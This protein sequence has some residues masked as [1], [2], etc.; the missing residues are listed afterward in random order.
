[1]P[2]FLAAAYRDRSLAERVIAALEQIGVP[3]QEISL[4]VREPAEEDVNTRAQLDPE[5]EAFVG[6]AVH[7][8]WERMGWQGG[9]RPAYRDRVPP[10]IE[11][12][13]LAAG[14]LAIG[15]GGAQ[16]GATA[17]G[18]VGGMANF[19]FDLEQARDWYDRIVD[20]QAF[21]MVGVEGDQI[22]DARDTMGRFSP[23]AMAEAARA[24]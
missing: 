23:E 2:T 24:W 10:N 13:F 1:M 5:E 22:G 9:A 18:I 12:A 6:L 3:H 17:G 16:I 8:A 15:L 20:G 4:V 14:P 19:G 7:S 11:M 21:V